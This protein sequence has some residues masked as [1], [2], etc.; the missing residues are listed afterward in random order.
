MNHRLFIQKKSN[1][2]VI[3]QK[4]TIELRNLV[5]TIVCKV[6][7]IYDLFNIEE[8]QLQEVQNKVFVDPVTDI[9]FKYAEDAVN[10]NFPFSKNYFATEYLPGQYNQRDDSAEQCLVLM[11]VENVN[12]KSGLLYVFNNDLSAE[13]LQK[14][15]NYLINPIESRQKDLSKMEIPA[16]PEATDVPT[17]EGFITTDINGLEEVYKNFGLSLEMDDLVFIQDHFKSINRNPTET[18]L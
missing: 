2:D 8:N 15:K 6:F 1:F 4:T 10:D 9:V 5:P 7:V 13:D 3:S 18:E 12:V 17:I 11:N 16:N 14:V